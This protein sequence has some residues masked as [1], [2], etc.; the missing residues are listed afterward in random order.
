[1]LNW[2]RRFFFVLLA[3]GLIVFGRV[4]AGDEAKRETSE[5]PPIASDQPDTHSPIIAHALEEWKGDFDGM[6][7]RGFVRLLTTYNPLYFGYNGV[8]QTGL[9]VEVARE[10]Q[11]HL[12]KITKTKKG[13]INVVIIPVERDELIPYLLAGKGDVVAA[14]LTV[15]PARQ[16]QV[17]FT[18]PTQRNVSELVVS[19]PKAPPIAKI[20]DLVST[21]IFVR[22]SSSYFE[23]LVAL[24]KSRKNAGKK[25]FPIVKADEI[26][27]DYD[28]LEMVN[29]G[30]LPAVIV[31]D[32]KAKLWAQVFDDITV[33]KELNVHTGGK[34]AWAIRKGDT[35]WLATLNKF[36]K[37][38]RKGSLLGNIL[39]KR[40]L[41]T[42]KWIDNALK[43]SARD[44]YQSTL[45]FI[46]RYAGEYDFDWLMIMAQGYQESKLDQEKRSHAGAVGI[47]QVLPRTAKDPNV[48]IKNISK[49]EPNVHAG[50]K[51]LDFLRDRYF[52]SD[53]MTPL[54]QM[55]FSF[56]A[57]NAGPRNIQRARNRAKKKGRDPNV[58]FGQT[59]IAAAAT[60]SREPVVYVRNI[61]KYYV[62]YRSLADIQ[63]DRKQLKE[64]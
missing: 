23:H 36:V 2:Q 13:E 4:A 40:Y 64:R 10:L 48:N 7:K 45:E 32:H 6:V 59:E 30:L 5:V 33:H 49:A 20:E 55:L 18:N 53:D 42:T 22:P 44:R 8:T 61:Y 58:W 34:T 50:V 60:I 54:N 25:K 12:R 27:E 38:I 1:M 37:K 29:A 17:A 43:E 52:S 46:K 31:D 56:A 15:T 3:A 16:A 35:K 28:L 14:N 11:L 47:M 9:A 57:Y 24:N 19:G 51:Y 63:S 21:K 41:G 62:A 26:L 39:V